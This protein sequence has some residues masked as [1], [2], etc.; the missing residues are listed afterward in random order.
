ML[1]GLGTFIVLKSTFEHVKNDNFILCFQKE[2]DFVSCIELY[3][4]WSSFPFSISDREREMCS[5]LILAKQWKVY[6]ELWILVTISISHFRNGCD[7]LLWFTTLIK[8]LCTTLN[9]GGRMRER[10]GKNEFIYLH[11]HKLFKES[12]QAAK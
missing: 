12:P 8:S 5:V 9:R 2:F 11:A 7:I 4:K 6:C 10:K 1:L 3:L